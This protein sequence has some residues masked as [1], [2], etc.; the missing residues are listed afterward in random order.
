M[1]L[2]FFALLTA[3]LLIAAGQRHLAIFCWLASMVILI[4]LFRAHATDTLRMI[5]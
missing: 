1:S 2:P 3:L 5:L 4:V